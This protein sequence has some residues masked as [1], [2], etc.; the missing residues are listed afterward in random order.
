MAL[1]LEQKIAQKEAEL[2]R[3]KTAQRKL[4]TGQ[5]IIIGGA[6]LKAAIHNP[7][8]A[9]WLTRLL[10]SAITRDIDLKRITPLIS[11]LEKNQTQ[12]Q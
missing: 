1:T 6:V 12:D 11:L 4:E 10:Q 5:K 8:V 3:L 2:A 9:A 7:E